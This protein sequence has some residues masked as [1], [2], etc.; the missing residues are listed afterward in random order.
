MRPLAVVGNVN[1]DLIMG[2]V[3]PWPAPGT[4]SVVD[5]D[6]M[7][8]GGA[9]GSVALAWRALHAP[10]QIAANVGSDQFGL[11]LKETF[12]GVSNLWPVADARTTISLGLTHPDGERTFFTT[13]GHLPLFD[14]EDALSCIDSEQLRG[15]IVLLC[16]T[17]VMPRL[18]DAYD[19]FFSWAGKNGVD[20]A[21]DTG[22]PPGGW[23]KETVAKTKGWLAHC[24]HL[25]LNE[26]EVASLTGSSNA[27]EGARVLVEH[28]PQ[29][30]SVVVVKR[31][32]HGALAYSRH[33]EVVNV[34]ALEIVLADTIGAGDAFDAG[35]LVAVASGRGLAEAV[36]SGVETASAAI[37]TVPRTYAHVD[38][39]SEPL[40]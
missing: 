40:R 25:L 22:W 23:R 7:R 6:E 20:V 11:F 18:M 29:S 32:R 4:E 16:G 38:R 24:R 15:G 1:V 2:P 8:A 34:P 13:K 19:D 39:D 27:E 17:F 35:Y 12:V 26:L 36:R 31:G 5:H 9:A 28:M 30:E 14:L 21:L 37:S 33:G 3:R 10:F